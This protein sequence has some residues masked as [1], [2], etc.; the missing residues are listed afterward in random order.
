MAARVVPFLKLTRFPLVFTAVADSAAGYLLSRPGPEIRW[1]TLALLALTS[2]SL[3]A[4]G[5]V[6]NDVADALRDRTLH[7]ERPIPSGQVSVRAARKFGLVL[8]FAGALFGCLVNFLC[9]QIVLGM[10]ILILAYNFYTKGI[11]AYGALTMALLRTGNFLLGVI[12]AVPREVGLIAVPTGGQGAY[13]QAGVLGGYVLFLTLVSSLEEKGGPRN[14]FVGFGIA[15]GLAPLAGLAIRSSAG[16][17]V[18]SAALSAA[19]LAHVLSVAGV[20][21]P[22]RIMRVVRW[23]VLA[24][25]PLDATFVLSSGRWIEGAALAGLA[26]P[27]LLLL[28]LFRR[29]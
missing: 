15:M 13:L 8:M 24:I 29:L 12:G 16:G 10:F 19:L 6:F 9:G 2:A 7:R 25:I 26:L 23:G 3:Y 11:P 5:M 28:P 18:G 21:S 4:C 22:G 17:I 14:L 27:A 1:P 20:L